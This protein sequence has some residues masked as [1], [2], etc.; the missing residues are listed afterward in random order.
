MRNRQ[1]FK[2]H[3]ATSV[4]T[5]DNFELSVHFWDGVT[6]IYDI[7]PLFEEIPVFKNIKSGKIK[8]EDV[9]LSPGG[10]GLI[11]NDNIDLSI[12][13]VWANGKTVQTAFDN[14]LSF[15]DASMIWG[16]SESALRKAVEYGKFTKGIDIC[17]YGKQWLI[18]R[19]AMEREYGVLA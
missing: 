18:S 3:R 2:F 5:L 12:E 11:W 7:K 6:K 1:Q 17:K 16:L 8:F 15:A 4:S 9:V 13:E 19:D 14:I 10:F